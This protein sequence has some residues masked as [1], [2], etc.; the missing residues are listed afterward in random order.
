MVDKTPAKSRLRKS[1]TALP[2]GVENVVEPV[3]VRN[4]GG[5]RG[6]RVRRST[7][8]AWAL[9]LNAFGVNAQRAFQGFAEMFCADPGLRLS[10]ASLRLD[11]S[12]F[13]LSGRSTGMGLG[14][15]AQRSWRGRGWEASAQRRLET[16]SEEVHR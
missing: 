4:F 2:N 5:G 7:G 10:A 12:P 8:D 6:P 11:L 15:C 1:F 13:A 9:E 16:L 3:G 14:A